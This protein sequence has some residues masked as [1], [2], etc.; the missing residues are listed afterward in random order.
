VGQKGNVV[1]RRTAI[2]L[3]S[4]AVIVWAVEPASSEEIDPNQGAQN[5]PYESR[6]N[7]CIEVKF[8]DDVPGVMF[9][10]LRDEASRIWVRH[11]IVLRWDRNRR[12]SCEARVP[13]VFSEHDV[14]RLGRHEPGD[15]LA[16][17]HFTEA[18]DKIYVSALRATRLARSALG[19]AITAAFRQT[20]TGRLLGRVVAHELGHVLLRTRMH[21]SSG[22]M[23]RVYGLADVLSDDEQTTALSANETQQ[24]AMRFSLRPATAV[25]VAS[26]SPSSAR[27]LPPF[28]PR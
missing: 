19:D 8:S 23:R 25:A 10:A 24:L 12:D 2:H 20:R 7:I 28:P 1:P 14:E 22:L 11:G 15:V 17:T 21:T 9:T 18:G 4:L 3:A 5:P 27:P 26:P 6:A 13:I 16:L